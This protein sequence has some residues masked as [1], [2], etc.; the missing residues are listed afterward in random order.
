M[1]AGAIVAPRSWGVT[2]LPRAIGQSG[3]DPTRPRESRLTE[4]R[5]AS[6]CLPNAVKSRTGRRARQKRYGRK[7]KKYGPLT[8]PLCHLR[9]RRAAPCVT[10]ASNTRPTS[11]MLCSTRRAVAP[12]PLLR[13]RG[14]G[15]GNL[16]FR[17]TYDRDLTAVASWLSRAARAFMPSVGTYV[18]SSSRR[19][20]VIWA[21]AAPLLGLPG[22][23][24]HPRGAGW[25]R[26]PCHRLKKH[27]ALPF[28]AA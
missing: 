4:Y 15:E 28:C 22:L 2:R 19:I 16:T 3:N 11:A 7:V 26:L 20:R 18:R 25:H 21:K 14:G 6:G 13:E 23:P 8:Q 17:S 9:R 5:Q 24:R 10:A 1:Q 27:R 12:R